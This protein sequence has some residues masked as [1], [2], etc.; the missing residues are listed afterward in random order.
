MTSSTGQQRGPWNDVWLV[1]QR[2]IS[3]R[4]AK[5]GYLVGLLVMVLAIF[6]L[7]VGIFHVN[8]PKTYSIAVCGAPQAAFGAAPEGIDVRTCQSTKSAREQT[9]S[10]NID[11][12]VTVA[13]GKAT[14][15][16]RPDT[17]QKTHDAAMGLG[18]Q[19]ATT[20]AY[21]EQH[22]DTTRLLQ[23]IGQAGPQLETVGE[24]GRDGKQLGA[25]ISLV[26]ILFMQIIGQGSLVAQG[27]VEEKSTRIVEVLLATLTP[28]RL[29]IGKV[30]GIGTTAIGQILALVGALVA[31]R[32]AA[33]IEDG[34]LPGVPAL[35]TSVVWFLLSFAL[36]ASLFAAAGSLVSRPDELQSVLMPVM[37]L[38]MAPIGVAVAAAG[39]LSSSWV[40]VVQYIPPFSGL[41]MPLQASVGGVSLAQQLA[42]AGGMLL[43]TAGCM[44]L[45][46]RV[47]RNS[48]LK[49]GAS[50]SWRQAL[51]A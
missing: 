38:A 2:E 23:S 34:M 22:V 7:V 41:L 18:R 51:T 19:W 12:A 47:Y 45:A 29:M 8:A 14:V 11:A 5:K 32:Y 30:A 36:F 48:I 31:A 21:Q 27:V 13:G 44:W 42:A 26:M 50:V 4:M 16:V 25:A 9:D 10:R 43:A 37:V 6:G 39:S 1:Y 15:L 33:D 35:I 17:D 46:A 20:A 3:A 49:L 28:G 40:G 24:G